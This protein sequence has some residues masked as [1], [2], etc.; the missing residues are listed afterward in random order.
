[1]YGLTQDEDKAL[2]LL[3]QAG[4][5]GYAD[6]YYNIG[7]SYDNGEGVEK[8]IKKANHYF[9]LSAMRG[10]ATARHNLGWMY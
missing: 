1:M 7:C 2:K 3:H 5:L 10:D 9:E 6:A 4:E 8:D